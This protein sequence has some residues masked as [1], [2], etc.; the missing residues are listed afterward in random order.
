MQPISMPSLTAL[1]THLLLTASDQATLS[2]LKAM[3]VQSDFH[4]GL[5]S[6][7]LPLLANLNVLEN[8]AL[9]P[10]YHN[11][12]S[13]AACLK[14]LEPDINRL[15][16]NTVLGQRQE[17]LTREQRLKALLLRCL[18]NGSGYIL[19]QSPPRSDCD[20]LDRALDA[21]DAGVFL[22]VCCLSTDQDI[23]SS[24]GYTTIDL[25]TLA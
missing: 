5:I 9:G 11:H 10:M 1:R 22:W 2:R 7:R 19:L 23:Y 13:L 6:D 17:F 4:V 25:D 18:A 21:L 16:L 15:G 20:T 24:L 3:T 8:I 12:M 14:K